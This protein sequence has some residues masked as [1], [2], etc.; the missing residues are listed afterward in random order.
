MYRKA[1]PCIKERIFCT[2]IV[3]ASETQIENLMFPDERSLFCIYNT[4]IV[5]NERET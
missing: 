5:T 1:V 2:K 4:K 3:Q